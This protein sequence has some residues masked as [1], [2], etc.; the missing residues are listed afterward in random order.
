M[1]STLYILSLFLG[2]AVTACN[3]D[4]PREGEIDPQEVIESS[5]DYEDGDQ[6]GDGSVTFEEQ[7]PYSEITTQTTN[8]ADRA[9]SLR[10]TRDS[11]LV[12]PVYTDNEYEAAFSTSTTNPRN[13]TEGGITPGNNQKKQ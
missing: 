3:S 8:Y 5:P 12:D 10:I 7:S 2:L 11:G 9:D 6:D 1:K 13:Q 4:E